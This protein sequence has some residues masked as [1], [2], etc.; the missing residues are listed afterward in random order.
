MHIVYGKEQADRLKEKYTVLELDTV[1][2][3]EVDKNLTLFAVVDTEK[4]GVIDLPQL[5]QWVKLHED[6]IRNLKKKDKNF[7]LQAV[8]HLL[9]KFGGD[10]DSFYE[11][12]KGRFDA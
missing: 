12:V 7:C 5:A 4:L 9:G 10:I 1:K 6:L 8:E 2:V 11:H 3:E